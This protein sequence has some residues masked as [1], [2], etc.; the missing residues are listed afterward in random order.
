MENKEKGERER[1][2]AATQ[3]CCGGDPALEIAARRVKP[4]S[5]L[6]GPFA[7]GRPI[8]ANEFHGRGVI[9]NEFGGHNFHNA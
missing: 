3:R 5:A 7:S 2:T 8:A 9:E 4:G 1:E 6:A